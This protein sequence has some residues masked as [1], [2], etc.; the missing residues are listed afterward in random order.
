MKLPNGYG[1][2]YRLHGNRRRPWCVRVTV[3]KDPWKY[4]YLG[5]YETQEDALTALAL[6]NKDPYDLDSASITF[7]EVYD[8]WSA[9]HFPKISQSLE[10][11]YRSSYLVCSPLYNMKF[12][13]IRLSHLQGV[14][15]H[16]GKNY[17]SLQKV[18]V[19]F[20]QLYTY[21]M[22]NDICQK[23]YA[24]YVDV[25]QYKDR[26]PNSIDRKSFTSEEINHL[27]SRSAEKAPMIALMLIYSGVR[28]GELL[29]L[30]KEN[31][32]LKVQWFDVVASKTAAGIRKVPI[33]D[34]VLPLF[35]KW[36][37]DSPCEYLICNKYGRHMIYN[38]FKRRYWVSGGHN[39][40]DTRHTCVSLLA[41]AGVDEKIIKRIVGHSGDGITDTIYTH[42]DFQ[43]L[44]DAINTI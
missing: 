13:D 4:K 35:Q 12:S 27:W 26:N 33:A 29:D 23:N 7:A 38:I 41:Q 32:N 34:K 25:Q 15:D 2:V 43:I 14:V 31:V 18:K 44:L 19:L 22:R 20:S 21:A 16:C 28:I 42:F 17:P 6:Y 1:S 11:V 5:Y 3:S 39:P 9:E 37:E 24:T 10:I 30:K 36:M 8:R 40:H